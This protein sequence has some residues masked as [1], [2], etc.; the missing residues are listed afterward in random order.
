VSGINLSPDLG[1]P[2]RITLA[3]AILIAICNWLQRAET[4]AILQ[5]VF[6]AAIAALTGTIE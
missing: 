3:R 2:C 5:A 6:F 4:D 1:A